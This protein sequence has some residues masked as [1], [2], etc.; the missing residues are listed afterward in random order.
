MFTSIFIWLQIFRQL[1]RFQLQAANAG[2][3]QL[4]GWRLRFQNAAERIRNA[5]HLWPFFLPWFGSVYIQRH[6]TLLHWT[7]ATV[8]IW[9]TA[10]N[11]AAVKSGYR[12]AVSHSS[13][14]VPA[15]RLV[16]DVCR[17]TVNCLSTYNERI[18][19]QLS[20]KR[21]TCR[22]I[23]DVRDWPH[24]HNCCNGLKDRLGN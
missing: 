6:L 18:G 9:L 15:V 21:Q 19:H 7:N 24:T 13:Y 11:S 16:T 12:R 2:S 3:N 1:C 23:S 17:W 14:C 10:T 4:P 22:H 20:S 5:T 8:N